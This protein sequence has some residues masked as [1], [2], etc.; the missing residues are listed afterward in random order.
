MTTAR[1]LAF[2]SLLAA[3]VGMLVFASSASSVGCSS[4]SVTNAPD[5]DLAPCKNGPF[6]FGCDSPVAGQ[7]ACNT[8]NSSD[9]VLS[10]LPQNTAYPVGCVV[11]Y[12]GPRDSQGDCRLDAVCKCVIGD[13][14]VEAGASSPDPVDAGSADDGGDASA[15]DAGTTPPPPS[16]TTTGP[17][18]LCSN[19]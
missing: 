6:L 16:V 1:T 15:A 19:Q 8:G 14:I 10:K 13:I 4:A 9:P 5:A 2:G 11:N 7:A 18:W 12:V 3:A 17:T